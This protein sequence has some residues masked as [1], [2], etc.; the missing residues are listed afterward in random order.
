MESPLTITTQT[1]NYSAAPIGRTAGGLIVL[2]GAAG[3][4]GALLLFTIEPLAAKALLPVLG[5][6]PAVW[7]TAMAF[8]Q[9]ALLAGYMIAH[10]TNTRLPLSWRLPIQLIILALPLLILPFGL[11]G[12][13]PSLES[14]V[15]W[16]LGAL[17]VMVGA[18]FFALATLSP[19][20]QAWF[21]RTAHPR[22]RDPFFLYA[23]SNVGSFLGLLA[24]PLVIEPRLDLV[25]QAKWFRWGYVL[26]VVV[27]AAAAWQARRGHVGT[28]ASTV[29]GPPIDMRR[30]LFWVGAAGIPS[31]MLLA[32]SRHIATDVASFPLLWV[33][34]LALYLATFVLAFSKFS[35]PIT[36]GAGLLFPFLAIPAAVAWSGVLTNIWLGLG[37]PLAL[38][39]ASGLLAHGRLYQDRPPA[40]RLTEFYLWISVGGAVGGLLGALV[41]PVV[42]DVIAEYPIAIVATALLLVGQVRPGRR[43]LKVVMGVLYVGSLAISLFTSEITAVSM[44]LGLAG[45]AAYG[46][47]AGSSWLA[48]G[49]AG[50]L[51]VG[52]L[53]TDGRLLSQERTFFGVYRVVENSKGDHMMVSGTTVHGVQRF[54]PEPALTPLAYYVP[55]G[56]FGHVMDQIGSNTDQIGVIGLGAGALASY[57]VAGQTLTYYEIDPAVIGLATDPKLFTYTRDTAGRV[58]YIVGDGRLTLEQPHPPFGLLIIDAF[59]SDAIPTHLL[60]LEATISYLGALQP[61]GVIGFHISNRHLDLEPVLG[62]IA[63]ELDL[64]AR[65]NHF[66]PTSTDGSPTTFVVMA[67]SVD[68]LGPLASDGSWVEPRIGL[69]LWTDTFTD[70]LGVIRW[71]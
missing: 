8:F 30:K 56:P 25:E 24:Y 19:S 61:R 37:L 62:R 13:R 51:A 41:A 33:V 26:L 50:L 18:P 17:A 45:V 3:F 58:E 54:D 43:P 16:E 9:V 22:A 34:P 36:S 10:L 55:E 66:Q 44:L 2:F 68:D 29:G 60:T 35:S 49:L 63:S 32:V 23:A 42:F 5:G 52:T 40:S 12:R 1:V 57:L 46:I 69:D 6:S 67:R 15:F 20:V 39:V 59:S 70:L 48:L 28:Q 53:Y 65:I 11:P 47:V 14:P 7:N 21:S 27:A 38:L 4:L 64:F 71:G 31:L